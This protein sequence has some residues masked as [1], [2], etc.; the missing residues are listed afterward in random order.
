[1]PDIQI[2]AAAS[3]QIKK[4]LVDRQ[5]P[6]AYLRLGVKGGNCAG[7]SYIIQFDDEQPRDRDITF[8]IQDVQ[9]VID[10]KSILYLDGAT[11]DWHSSLMKRGFSIT[12]PNETSR[13]GCGKSFSFK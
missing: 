5:T 4:Q 9:I 13:C 7:F 2:T 11:L 3:E 10:K 8:N 1:M 6:N 12:N